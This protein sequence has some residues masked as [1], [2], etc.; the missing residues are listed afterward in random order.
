MLKNSSL[1]R[2][3]IAEITFQREVFAE[4][5]Q[6]EP[7]HALGSPMQTFTCK[8]GNRAFTKN[9]GRVVEEHLVH[10]A[11]SQ[12]R[13]VHQRST[14]DQQAGDLQFSQTLDNRGEVGASI[15]GRRYLSHANSLRFQRLSR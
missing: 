6:L 2:V 5:V 8:E 14:F 3:R 4:A 9:L 13:A 10:L 11:G 7:L 15:S 12:G 1:S